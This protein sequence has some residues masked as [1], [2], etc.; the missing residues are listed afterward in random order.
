MPWLHP[1]FIL[2]LV[3]FLLNPTCRFA[4]FKILCPF[5]ILVFYYFQNTWSICHFRIVFHIPWASLVAQMLK[6][7]P[8]MQETWVQSVGLEEENGEGN[9]NPLQYSCLG[10]PI[11]RGPWQTKVHGAAKELDTT[12]QL[13]HAFTFPMLRESPL[14][15]SLSNVLC[16]IKNFIT[17]KAQIVSPS[18]YILW[19]SLS[20]TCP[21]HSLVCSILRVF[22]SSK[23]LDD[24]A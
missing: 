5:A 20:S 7:L 9:G 24:I 6:N 19:K 21:N 10:N 23:Q 11:N 14:I 22:L 18:S 17:S 2:Y 3:V 12:E 13:T 16:S 15:I 8:A 4:I 1:T